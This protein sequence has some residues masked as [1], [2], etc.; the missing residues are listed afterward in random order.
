ML[1]YHVLN[2]PC[3]CSVAYDCSM[4]KKRRAEEQALG[5]PVNKRKSL[6]MKPRH[7]SPDVDCKRDC[8]DRMEDNSLLDTSNR[9]T[10]GSK[11]E[12]WSKLYVSRHHRLS[13]NLWRAYG[14]YGCKSMF[15]IW[16]QN[17]TFILLNVHLL[18]T[19]FFYQYLCRLHRLTRH[20]CPEFIFNLSLFFKAQD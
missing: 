7:Y 10:A 12:E 16:K 20:S 9:S 8:D 11:E 1:F 19:H 18:R 6:L 15:V 2:L 17:R 5:V 14:W 3:L 13:L 4:A